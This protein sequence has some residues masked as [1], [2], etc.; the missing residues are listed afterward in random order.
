MYVLREQDKIIPS[1]FG[2]FTK[3]IRPISEIC[4][5]ELVAWILVMS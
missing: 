2:F 3:L 4:L 1:F 5:A